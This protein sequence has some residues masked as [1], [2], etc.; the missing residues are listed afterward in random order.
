MP[1][2]YH[3]FVGHDVLFSPGQERLCSVLCRV[4]SMIFRRRWQSHRRLCRFTFEL[5][6]SH[7]LCLTDGLDLLYPALLLVPYRILLL[8]GGLLGRRCGAESHS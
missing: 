7:S 2:G 4:R 1:A 6:T 8:M 5:N 3:C